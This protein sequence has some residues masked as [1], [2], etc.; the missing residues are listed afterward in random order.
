MPQASFGKEVRKGLCGAT[1]VRVVALGCPI[2]V[3][4]ALASIPA[5]TRSVSLSHGARTRLSLAHQS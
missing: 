5:M 4:R 2:I 3:T 1:D